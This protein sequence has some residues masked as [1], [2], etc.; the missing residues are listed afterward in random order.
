MLKRKQFSIRL[1][2]I[3]IINKSQKQSLNTINVNLRSSAFSHEQLYVALLRVTNV[4]RLALLL[5]SL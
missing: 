5:K 3:T 2:F 4:N 1:C